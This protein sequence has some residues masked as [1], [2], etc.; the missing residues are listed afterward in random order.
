[1]SFAIDDAL[2]DV[3][4]GVMVFRIEL[5]AKFSLDILDL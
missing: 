4:G 5:E 2:R 1:L 3:K